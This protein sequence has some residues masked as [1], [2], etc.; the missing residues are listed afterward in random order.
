MYLKNDAIKIKTHVFVFYVPVMSASVKFWIK[1]RIKSK[2]IWLER[3]T[4]TLDSNMHKKSTINK[5]G[6]ICGKS[7]WIS[8][9]FKFIFN[10]TF[11]FHTVIDMT[12]KFELRVQKRFVH[13]FW[14]VDSIV[15]WTEYY[16]PS[17]KNWTMSENKHNFGINRRLFFSFLKLCQITFSHTK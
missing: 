1:T 11:F 5:I 12:V 13:H 10:F 9:K 17:L 16:V 6:L 7:C 2:M 8:D 4:F 3:K 15:I 14:K